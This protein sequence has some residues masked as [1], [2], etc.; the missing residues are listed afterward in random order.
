MRALSEAIAIVSKGKH[1][2]IVAHERI[3][4]FYDWAHVAR[5]TEAV[6]R[7]VL[8]SESRDL[9]TRMKRCVRDEVGLLL[10]FLMYWI[11]LLGRSV[12]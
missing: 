3:K 6:Y 11:W 9:W 5:R 7:S 12:T 4:G 8:A 1:N 10:S 2:P